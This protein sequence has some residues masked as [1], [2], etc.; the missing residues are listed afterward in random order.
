MVGERQIRRLKT[1]EKNRLNSLLGMTSRADQSIVG[2][3]SS[4]ALHSHAMQGGL[5]FDFPEISCND[6]NIG[7]R[8]DVNIDPLRK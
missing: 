8:R 7:M 3:T 5:S 4:S 1:A 2:N 6:V